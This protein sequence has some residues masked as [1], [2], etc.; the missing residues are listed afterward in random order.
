MKANIIKLSLLSLIMIAQVAISKDYTKLLPQE[1]RSTVLKSENFIPNEWKEFSKDNGKWFLSF[2]NHTGFPS[3]AFGQPIKISGFN[4]IDKS[5]IIEAVNN[6]LQQNKKY[7]NIDPN[8]LS[9][10]KLVKVKNTWAISFAQIYNDMEVLLSSVEFKVRDDGYIISF[11][12]KYFDN[13]NIKSSKLINTDQVKASAI[14]GMSIKATGN[15]LESDSKSYILPLINGNKTSFALVYKYLVTDNSDINTGKWYSYVDANTG[16]LLWRKPLFLDA[17]NKIENS[18]KKSYPQDQE[19][20]V[21]LADCYVTLNNI[22]FTTDSSGQ[23]ISDLVED[24]LYSFGFSGPWCNVDIRNTQLPNSIISG[25][26]TS[27]VLEGLKITMATDNSN[28]DE[29][30]LFNYT[31]EAHDFY[32]V[33][34]PDSK[35]M[36][37]QCQVNTTYQSTPNASSDLQTGNIYFYNTNNPSIR[38]VETPSVLFHEYGHSQNTRLYSEVGIP[39]GMINF[40]CHEAMADLN[41]ALILNDSKIGLGAW[42]NNPG[43]FIR[44]INNNNQYPRDI[45]DDSHVTGL[46]LAGAYWDLVKVLTVDTVRYLAH[47]TKKLGTPDDENLGLAFEEWFI[48]TLTTDDVLYGDADLSNGTPHFLQILTAFN[49]HK[50][51]TNL[52]LLNSFFHIPY[53]DTD[54]IVNDYIINFKL[55]TELSFFESKP[56]NVKLVYFLNDLNKRYETDAIEISPLNWQAKIPAQP[57]GTTINYYMK[58]TEPI[59]ETNLDLFSNN[60]GDLYT[61]LV[62]Y[63]TAL[64][65]DFDNDNEGW[66]VGNPQDVVQGGNWEWGI[67]KPYYLYFQYFGTAYPLQS[68]G[69]HRPISEASGKCWATGLDNGGDFTKIVAA[70]VPQGRTTI[71]SPVYDVSALN[72]PIVE[73]WRWFSNYAFQNYAY[74]VVSL[75][76]DGGQTWIKADSTYE[77]EETIWVNQRIYLSKYFKELNNLKIRF[78]FYGLPANQCISEGAIDDIKILSGNDEIINSVDDINTLK[79]SS[80]PNPVYSEFTLKY[81]SSQ[82]SSAEIMLYNIMGENLAVLY[83]GYIDQGIFSQKF[84]LSNYPSGVYFIR[85]NHNNETSSTRIIKR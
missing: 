75:S 6:F 72:N 30:Y 42:L 82:S 51:G 5:N 36:D 67:P 68:D 34:D 70:Y 25:T 38:F 73:Y 1:S 41:S 60:N 33:T 8:T 47:Y 79:I 43:R 37:F 84:D 17:V 23:F 12:V 13:I 15:T 45:S 56:T 81:Y 77:S 76:N 9:K 78:I 61:F 69:D 85:I 62:G 35:A 10:R 66:A 27:E 16:D 19:G 83:S 48:E 29:R 63:A 65:L 39:E 55:G 2:D 4:N 21:P 64:K 80:Y 44:D 11:S 50:I 22:T 20:I 74:W 14:Q 52:L 26:V 31:N 3:T 40:S 24:Q 57:R 71:E 59:T 18:V 53:E 49:N 7:F 32:K 28:L 54:D 58:A 46:I